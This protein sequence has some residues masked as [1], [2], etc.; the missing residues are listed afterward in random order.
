MMDVEDTEWNYKKYSSE[1]NVD[2]LK[3]AASGIYQLN[4]S[5]ARLNSSRCG[6]DHIAAGGFYQSDFDL[7]KIV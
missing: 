5:P 4:D 1:D 2:F 6:N 3:V 7:N